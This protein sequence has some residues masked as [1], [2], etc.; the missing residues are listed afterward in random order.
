MN[1]LFFI[2][3]LIAGLILPFVFLQGRGRI[4]WLSTMSIIGLTVVSSEIVSKLTTGM[5]ISQ[6]FWQW[7]LK[8]ES[9]AWIVLF[10]LFC[11]WM[12]LL[13]HLA[14]KILARRFGWKS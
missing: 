13:I 2:I 7:S 8:H 12:S 1:E 4:F 14:W 5:T 3:A 10:M 6:H 11:G 9:T